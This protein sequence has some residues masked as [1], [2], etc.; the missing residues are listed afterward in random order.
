[1]LLFSTWR[2]FSERTNKL[3]NVIFFIWRAKLQVFFNFFFICVR[4]IFVSSNAIFLLS[5]FYDFITFSLE[6]PSISTHLDA[7]SRR[8]WV[9]FFLNWWSCLIV[10]LELMI[11][12]SVGISF[13]FLIHFQGSLL[14]F[15]LQNI[16]IKLSFM[17]FYWTSSIFFFSVLWV[18][19]RHSLTLY[20]SS[21]LL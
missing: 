4:T 17:L 12:M 6:K 5:N 11:H 20:H 15:N 8:S 9:F 1:M 3:N 14:F 18:L 10:C 21:K 13:F 16:S 7:F 2:A 19:Q